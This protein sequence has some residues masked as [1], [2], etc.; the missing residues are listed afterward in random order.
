MIKGMKDTSDFIKWLEE[1]NKL[2]AAAARGERPLCP[3]CKKGH[4][5]CKGKSFYYCDNPDYNAK[6][7]VHLAP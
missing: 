5:L 2:F 7:T 6:T 4:L 1:R 3:K